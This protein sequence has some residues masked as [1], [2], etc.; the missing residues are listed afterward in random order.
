[1]A[2]S[3]DVDQAAATLSNI[4]LSPPADDRIYFSH[5]EVLSEDVLRLQEAYEQDDVDLVFEIRSRL[6]PD[7]QKQV[8]RT[9]STCLSLILK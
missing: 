1:M 6:K 3:A 2:S 5:L 8:L 9:V 7:E 4:H